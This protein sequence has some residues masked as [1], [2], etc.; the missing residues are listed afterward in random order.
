[1]NAELDRYKTR[2]DACTLSDGTRPY[3]W[4]KRY[5]RRIGGAKMITEAEIQRDAARIAKAQTELTGDE[6]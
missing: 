6:P 4:W 1:M 2:R 3:A 5:Q